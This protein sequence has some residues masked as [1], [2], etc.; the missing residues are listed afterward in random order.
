MSD[1]AE[2]SL[3]KAS[4]ERIAASAIT[5]LMQSL[6]RTYG[7]PETDENAFHQWTID[8]ADLFWRFLWDDCEV[9]GEPGSR[10]VDKANQMPGA[11]WF[12]EAQINYAENLLRPRPNTETTIVFRREEG[13]IQNM[14]FGQL[15]ADVSRCA[16]VLCAAGVSKGDRVVAYMPN[17]PETLIAMLAAASLGAVFSSASPD[18]GVRGVLDR[19]GQI[20]PKVLIATNGYVYN[21]KTH[22]RRTEIEEIMRGLPSLTQTLVVSFVDDPD[23]TFQ[24]EGVSDWTDRLAYYEPAPLTFRRVPFNHPLFIMFSSGT[25]GAP[26]CIVHGHGGT[27]LQHLKEHR[28]H[29]DIRA[30]DRMFYFTTCGWMMWNWLVSGL[31]LKA[32]VCLFDG[33]PSYPSITSLFDYVNDAQISFF[34][35]SAKFIEAL[36]NGGA[37]P[38]WSHGLESL[39]TIASTGS[40]LSPD[41]FDYVHTNIKADVHL[42]SIAGGTDIVGCFVTG[43]PRLPVRRGEIQGPA[44]AMDVAVFDSKGGRLRGTPGELVCVNTFPSMPA[45]FWKDEDGSRYHAAYFEKFENVWAHGDWAEQSTHNGFIIHGRSDATLNPGGVRIGTAEIYRVVEGC[46]DVT[47]A[48]VV[49]QDWQ[50]DVRVILFVV[51]T[52]GATF[53]EALIADLKER[54][55][56]ECSPRHTPAKVLAVTDI[57]R[58]R[59]GKIS[60]LAVR[61]VIHGRPIKN[62]EALANPHTLDQYK[63]RPELSD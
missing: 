57:P 2:D 18:F 17:C 15:I 58:T 12:P 28:Y 25:T 61:D 11:S 62:T 32:T 29:L 35:T 45:G 55:R 44:L 30:K 47:D 27:L 60:E 54:V 5:A 56:K 46:D 26:K 37:K 21:G 13:H 33:S 43:N 49:G 51:M 59:S 7:A 19:F 14:T 41:S 34:G 22:G 23:G 3:W 42:A 1:T 50:D 4:D 16:K 48:L 20:E 8:H 31:A 40:P 38:G 63:D 9:I 52:E 36:K 53:S 24:I 10:V 39:R 6:S